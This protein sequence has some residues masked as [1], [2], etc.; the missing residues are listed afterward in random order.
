MFDLSW[1]L[2]KFYIPSCCR[3]E[4]DLGTQM[5][6]IPGWEEAAAQL[7]RGIKWNKSNMSCCPITHKML[8]GTKLPAGSP[9]EKKTKSAHSP[10]REHS[11]TIWGKSGIVYKELYLESLH[12]M[13]LLRIP[14]FTPTLHLANKKTNSQRPVDVKALIENNN[15]NINL[16]NY[17][18]K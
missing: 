11:D 8:D 18:S 17:I 12:W 4:N 13:L 15:I 16:N 9:R 1:L 6:Q 14:I 7:L 3:A 2:L 5:H 10:W